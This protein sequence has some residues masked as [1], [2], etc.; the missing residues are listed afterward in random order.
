VVDQADAVVSGV[1]ITVFSVT[2]GF[3]RSTLTSADGG[4]V[5]QLLPP[6]IYTV[7]A[8]REGFSPTELRNVIVNV[9]DQSVIKMHLRVGDITQTIEIVDGASLIDDSPAVNNV[10]DR[11][12]VENLPLNGRSFQ[13][14]IT[15]APGVVL[16][17]TNG[18]NPG[19]FS[20]NGQRTNTNYF[21]VDG[22]SANIGIRATNTLSQTAGGSQPGLNAFGGTN[23]LVSV[24]ALQ[25]FKILTSTYAPEFGR[26]PGAQVSIVTRSGGNDFHGSL[27]EYVRN[28]ALDASDW[29][30]NANRTGKPPLR[31]NDFG[32][33]FSGPVLL[34]RF[35][36][37]GNQPGYNGRNHTFFFFSYEGLRQRLP[38]VVTNQFVP[39]LNLRQNAPASLQPLLRAFPLP[40]GPENPT[41]QLA[42]LV[43]SFSSPN[44]LDATSFRVDHTFNDR[45][46]L[47]GRF[48]YAP[49]E[50]VL[51][52]AT[53]TTLSTL[54]PTQIGT[55]TLT[56][57]S[58]QV[59]NSKVSN[60]LRGNWSRTIAESFFIQDDF[61]GAV[62]PPDS[63]WFPSFASREN[64]RLLLSLNFNG[65][66]TGIS[67]GNSAANQ[68]RQINIVDSLSIVA[69]NHQLKVGVDYR[70][71]SP[72]YGPQ[73]YFQNPVFN[74]ATA[75]RTGTVSALS[76][77]GNQ[78]IEPIYTNFSAFTQDTWKINQR[79]TITYGLR[80]EVNPPPS[81][82]TGKEPFN[83]LGLDNPSTA[84][85][86]PAGTPLY[87][88][89]YNNFAPRIGIAYRILQD[90]RRDTVQRGGFGIFY[91]LG[92]G[93]TAQGFTGV[94]YAGTRPQ[95]NVPYPLSA[96]AVAPFTFNAAPPF[97]SPV[98]IRAFDPNLQLP[99]TYQWNLALERS[100]GLS[101][102]VSASYVAAAGRRLLRQIRLVNLV[103][104]LG[105]ASIDLTNN[106][107][108]SDYHALQVQYNRRLSRGLQALAS[109]T[110]SHSI[111]NAS[112]EF[113]GTSLTR[114]ASDFDIRHVFNAAVTYD[115]PTPSIGRVGK[116]ILGNFSLDG[117]VTARSAAP[118][119][120][121]ARLSQ[122]LFGELQH[123]RPDLI[124]GVP[125]YLDDPTLPGG[126][127]FNRTAL[128]QPPAGRQGTLG[129]NV[130]RGFPLSQ[131][132][133]SL[134]RQFNLTERWNLQLRADLFNIFNHPNF[135]DPELTP[136]VESLQNPSF[137]ISQNMFGRAI[138][139]F[140]GGF[141]PL[142]QVG[143]PRSVQLSFKLQF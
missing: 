52:A 43:A 114:A 78:R 21:T 66:F 58:T 17:R 89:T 16:T 140:G 71:L 126:R 79:L 46:T 47:F 141:S 134:R 111:D 37:G 13:S 143:G 35:G 5:I 133:L 11:Q 20:V 29:F 102:T 94:P 45:V 84:T 109:Y 113:S 57:G 119:N 48:N 14:L 72:I 12:F 93:Q 92:S 91:D 62:P 26:T 54:N 34:P 74:N 80:Y 49:S 120:V 132:D 3:Q 10:V 30:A 99:R 124:S 125:L 4:F 38:Q 128:S 97:A 64:D 107:G 82:A 31:Q 59:L 81:E 32:G 27:F 75:V 67:V 115:L 44:S 100:L 1:S 7:K 118:V 42:P 86:A 110:W 83:V 90:P 36:E 138:G 103:P 87:K 50:S 56:I 55:Q 8:E 116:A 129:R 142:Y 40:T 68:Q 28:D 76:I 25:E 39:S 2:Q 136:G 96:A 73:T 108:T 101:Q 117:I 98:L 85:L 23:N 77:G 18:N 61:G 130:F 106:D 53:S 6:G 22:V 122:T 24:D 33:V 65:I 51:R 95:A 123:I 105:N 127:R 137:G 104:S 88:T 139:R 69:G 135:G 70:R 112:D 15:M 60:E 63:V 9:N 19:Q 121:V 41:T 131:V